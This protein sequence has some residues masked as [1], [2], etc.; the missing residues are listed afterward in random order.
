MGKVADQL[1]DKGI[2]AAIGRRGAVHGRDVLGLG[3]I[4]V[5]DGGDD[6]LIVKPDLDGF[7]PDDFGIEER[8]LLGLPPDIVPDF[9]IE[10]ADLRWRAE[11]CGHVLTG[12]GSGMDF[13]QFVG[14][15][16]VAAVGDGR[17]AGG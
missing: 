11:L 12:A 5:G 9:V 10:G 13:G 1:L 14:I 2:V 7:L 17:R 3:Q 6:A 8:I 15:E 16:D 4:K